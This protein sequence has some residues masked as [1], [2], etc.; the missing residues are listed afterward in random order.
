M[1]RYY[2][3][4]RVSTTKQGET[5]VSLQEQRNAIERYARDKG[6]TI[7]EWFEEQLTAAKGGRPLF[8]RMMRDLKLGRASGVV[9][10]KIDRSARNLRDWADLG[11]LVDAG[12][13]VYFSNEPLDL[14]SR[15]GR[16]SADIQAVIASDFIRNLREET[17]KGFYGR[18]KQGFYPMPAP[19][20]YLDQGTG[21]A[22]VPDSARAPL[23]SQCFELYLTGAY[24]IVDLAAEM[25][26]RG[27][28]GK[29]GQR[30]G[31]HAISTILRNY[32]YAGVIRIAK[33]GETF[34]G[35]HE[36]IVTVET[37]RAV[38]DLL[39]GKVVRTRVIHDYLFRGLFQCARC[40]RM[41]VGE[42]QKGV[43]YYR[44]HGKNCSGPMI[45]EDR[46]QGSVVRALTRLEFTREEMGFIAKVVENTKETDFANHEIAVNAAQASLAQ[47][48]ARETRLT[49]AYLDGVIDERA[50]RERIAALRL[51][52][53]EVEGTLRELSENPDSLPNWLQEVLERA[54]SAYLLYRSG[55][56]EEKR[57]LVKAL[58][59][60]RVLDPKSPVFMLD[61]AYQRVADRFKSIDGSPSSTTIRTPEAC[62]S[63]VFDLTGMFSKEGK[64]AIRRPA[65]LAA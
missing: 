62:T 47:V 9:M 12:V 19:L 64:G 3:Y 6:L 55:T 40:S 23:V 36:P 29:R 28:R 5:G 22:K 53:C 8:S 32:F 38:Q 14:N 49:D 26:Q 33:T 48:K 56:V 37:F 54:K 31:W 44:C 45:R 17:K 35:L 2:A 1:N 60:N 30:V 16:L 21:K 25:H 59:S 46:L 42:R 58:C 11:E 18:L 27:L 39:N 41:I 15:G 63:L 20:G 34:Q 51:E 4:T 13:Q 65:R 50:Y 52:R 10:H 57:Q 7:A 61:S 43:V 24:T